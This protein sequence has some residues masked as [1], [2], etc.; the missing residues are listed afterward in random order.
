GTN[1]G[2]ATPVQ[3]GGT[4]APAPKDKGGQ[5]NEQAPASGTALDAKAVNDAVAFIRSLAELRGRNADWAEQAVR[6]AASLSATAALEQGAIE[7]VARDMDELMTR[8]D[9]RTVTAAG[10]ERTLR[11]QGLAL[12]RIEPNWRTRF[13]ATITN[14]NVALILMMIG[15]YGLFFEFMNPGALFPGTIGAICL[16]IALYALAALPVN[17][18]GAALIL[19]GLALMTAEAFAPSFGILGIGGIVAFLLGGTILVDTDIPEFRISWPTVAA[20]AVVSALALAAIARL[21]FDA[22]RRRIVSGVEEMIGARGTVIDWNQGRGHAFVHSERW[23]A[24]GPQRL[25]KG[26]PVRVTRVEG[27]ALTVEPVEE[28]GG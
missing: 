5:G 1:V 7:I 4:P 9:G 16:L 18:A 8:L 20:L 3:I 14:P 28:G 13:L 12:V 22:R 24:V 11:T 23:R 19:L 2:A 26:A 25:T 10:A 6:R 27:L 15:V 21:A 17:F